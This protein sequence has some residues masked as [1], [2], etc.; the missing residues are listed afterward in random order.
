MMTAISR[1]NLTNDVTF[2]AVYLVVCEE[3]T[4]EVWIDLID[5]LL[6][7]LGFFKTDFTTH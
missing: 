1:M 7:V 5:G 6:S 3:S 4:Y 2:S